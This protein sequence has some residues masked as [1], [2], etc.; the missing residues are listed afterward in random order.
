MNKL[1]WKGGVKIN[2]VSLPPYGSGLMYT[3]CVG[4]ETVPV[5]V[6][7]VI[8]YLAVASVAAELSEEV[9]GASAVLTSAV[10]CTV[11][12]DRCS[13]ETAVAVSASITVAIV[14]VLS[15][16]TAGAVVVPGAVASAVLKSD[17]DGE[18]TSHDCKNMRIM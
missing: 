9:R 12:W 6:S 15:A 18:A 7:H 16:C 17:H 10:W 2:P 3:M 4:L 1:S 8:I 14:A 13:S 5:S 11:A